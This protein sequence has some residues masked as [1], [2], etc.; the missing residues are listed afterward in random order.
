M[1]LD[2]LLQETFLGA[3]INM[4]APKKKGTGVKKGEG[5]GR[6]KSRDGDDEEDYED[7]L[8]YQPT[9]IE[10]H[11]MQEEKHKL[12]TEMMGETQTMDSLISELQSKSNSPATNVKSKIAPLVLKISLGYI[13]NT[14][15]DKYTD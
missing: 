9:S 3:S 14:Q 12:G 5:K 10:Q 6:P 13:T 7:Y 2:S 4:P 8:V 11:S 15:I 1:G